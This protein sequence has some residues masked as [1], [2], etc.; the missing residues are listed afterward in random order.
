MG[1]MCC[2]VPGQ[3]AGVAAALSVKHGLDLEQ[4]DIGLLQQE[5]RRQGVR[6]H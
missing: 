1:S 4:M 2:T 3:G 6:L 5:L